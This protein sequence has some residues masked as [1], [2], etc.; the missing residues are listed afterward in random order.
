[1]RS[2][3]PLLPLCALIPLAG[4]A[5]FPPPS[6]P[7]SRQTQPA[8]AAQAFIQAAL[9]MQGQP[10]RY[11]GDSPGGFDCSGL[12]L[13]A[14]KQAGIQV[15]RTAHS[16]LNA[17]IPVSREELRPGDLVFMRL[18]AKLHVGIV[19]AAGAFVHAPA[20]GGRVRVDPLGAQPY[21]DGFI[22]ARRIIP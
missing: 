3:H 14:A 18:P 8:P 17:G 4:C 19:T 10:Y 20:T 5:S 13:Y 16:Q 21:R 12:V 2:S 9:A 7:P 1:L 11:G 15:P 22:G 6:Y